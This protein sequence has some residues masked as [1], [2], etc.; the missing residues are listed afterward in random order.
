MID[1]RQRFRLRIYETSAAKPNT[2]ASPKAM[3]KRG[4]QALRSSAG[5]GDFC[6]YKKT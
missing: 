4:I 6:I 5:F 2:Q 3:R 1:T